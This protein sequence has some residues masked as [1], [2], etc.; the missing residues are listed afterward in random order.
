MITRIFRHASLPALLAGIA[1]PSCSSQAPTP[2][3]MV[4]VTMSSG[5]NG[6]LCPFSDET[7]AQIGA[8]TSPNPNTVSDGDTYAGYT[9]QVACSVVPSGGGF[10]VQASA[11]ISGP[12][13]GSLTV[14]GHVDSSGG[15]GLHGGF[16]GQGGQSYD[17]ETGCTVTYTM[18]GNPVP[19]AGGGPPVAAGRIWGHIDCP[20]AQ[21]TAS[22]GYASLPDGG[23]ELKTCEGQADFLFANCTGS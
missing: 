19:P 18:K 4:A 17:Q 9:V 6:I 5:S 8:P 23:S 13:G 10:D 14:T 16:T 12:Q 20:S 15:T 22:S 2:E 7:F 3:A 21:A 1:V 11:A